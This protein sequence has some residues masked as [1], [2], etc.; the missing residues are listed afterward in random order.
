MWG[1]GAFMVARVLF[2]VLPWRGNAITPQHR[3]AIKAL[4]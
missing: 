2:P 3:A 1:R 4:Q